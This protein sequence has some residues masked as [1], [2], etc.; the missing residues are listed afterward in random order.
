MIEDQNF[1]HHRDGNCIKENDDELNFSATP[2]YYCCCIVFNRYLR[3]SNKY[4]QCH[5]VDEAALGF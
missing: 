2:R 4:D 5:F 1:G 3:C